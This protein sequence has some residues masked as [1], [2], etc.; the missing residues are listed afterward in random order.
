MKLLIAEDEE[1][2][3]KALRD[4]LSQEPGVELVL[5]PD[6]QEALDLL[7]GGLRPQ[8]CLIDIRM[9]RL[10]GLQLLQRIRRDPLLRELQVV[11]SSANRDRNVILAFA[12]LGISGYLLK[13]YDPEKVRALFHKL[14]GSP[15]AATANPPPVARNP[16]AKTLLIVDDE[17]SIRSAL[18]E[19][20]ATQP[21]WE[22]V[23]APNGEEALLLLK[24]G[25]RPA[26][27]ICDLVMP[28]LD[29]FGF[30]HHVR[31]NPAFSS[32]PIVIISG[33][34]SAITVRQLAEQR[35]SGYL[36]KPFDFAKVTAML[37]YG[38][39]APSDAPPENLSLPSQAA[40]AP[41]APPRSA[42]DAGAAQPPDQ[43]QPSLRE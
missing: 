20:A 25:L 41:A 13:P 42:N 31:D 9:P 37:R 8:L 43:N 10:D 5:T 28:K 14:C 7:C 3:R 15:V 36:L 6:G 17:Q 27:C 34:S 35:I 24:Q 40:A 11:I 16:P 22:V 39:E 1:I 21:G 2:E 18:R 12:Q 19:A 30:V 26:L 38:L 29:G 4:I 33:N 32:M 23:E